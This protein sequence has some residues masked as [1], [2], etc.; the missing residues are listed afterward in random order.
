MGEP[1]SAGADAHENGKTRKIKTRKINE[2]KNQDTTPSPITRA[3]TPV[4]QLLTVTKGSSSKG[5]FR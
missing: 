3:M 5:R 2:T 1:M 4:L